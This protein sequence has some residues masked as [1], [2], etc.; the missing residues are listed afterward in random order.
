MSRPGDLANGEREASG[1]GSGSG[2]D[3]HIVRLES[4]ALASYLARHYR[5]K[6][7]GSL[8]WDIPTVVDY[9]QIGAQATNSMVTQNTYKDFI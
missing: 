7:V 6:L 8:P 4:C 5:R 1:H 3:D 9:R 2:D